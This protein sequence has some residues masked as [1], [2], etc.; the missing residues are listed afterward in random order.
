MNNTIINIEKAILST[1]IFNPI[2]IDEINEILNVDDFIMPI[3]KIIYQEM[4]E[5]NKKDLPI[6]EE[7]L[8]NNINHTHIDNAII[9]ILSANAISNHIAYCEE[10]KEFSKKRKI[11][12]LFTEI[13]NILNENSTNS[14]DIIN[15]INLELENIDLSNKTKDISTKEILSELLSDMNKAA[16]NE[17]VLGQKSGLKALDNIIGAFEDGD[18]IVI[19]ARPSMGKTSI[20]S[21]ITNQS[22]NDGHGVLIESLEMPAKKI[23]ARLISARSGENLSNIKKGFISNKEKFNEAANFFACENLI[24]NDGTYP[25]LT[26]LQNRIKKALRKNKKIKNIFIDHTGKIQLDGK[27]REDIEI[28]QITNSLKKI[29]RDNNIRV[30]LL[31]QLNRSVESRDNKRP[32]LS[33]LKN[34]GNIEEDADVVLGLYRDSY[35]KAKEKSMFENKIENAEIIILKNRDGETRTAKVAFEGRCARFVDRVESDIPVIIEFGE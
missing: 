25:T 24:I 17:D 29:A 1:I 27:T 7:F 31:Q 15:K 23:L 6:D 12:L 2:L 28:G 35:Y 26:Q 33:D 22:L 20:I 10:L 3:N 21:A 30:F 9:E 16:L 19:A 8:R 18:L 14:E 32:M 13:K 4:N 11:N 5:L 34:S